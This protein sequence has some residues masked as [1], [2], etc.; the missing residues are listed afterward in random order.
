MR[1]VS[2]RRSIWI[3]VLIILVLGLVTVGS[4]FGWQRLSAPNHP[5]PTVQ[6]EEEFESQPEPVMIQLP[7]AR[8]IVAVEGDY[9]EDSHIWRLISKSN[10]LSDLDY[11]PD[12]IKPDVATRQD[13]SLDEQ[14]VRRDIAPFVEQ[15]FTAAEAAGHQLQIGSGFRSSSLQNTYYTN[16]SRVYGQAAADTFSAKPGYSEHQTGLVVDLTTT[17]H[18]CYLEA[19]F[20]ETE[21]GKWLKENSYKYGFILRY[22]LE[23]E[24]IT[25][26]NYEP[27]HF[28]Y[29]GVALAS[30]LY[31]SGLSLDEAAP[32]LVD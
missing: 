7:G 4:W 5:M 32:Y 11:R 15:L 21:A 23:K 10:P 6:L 3:F 24:G 29:V 13:K 12:I 28:R 26:F 14:S 16:Y 20:G 2:Q 25:D 8:P 19:C 1:L 9:R 27:W 22:P 18:H 31:E 17:D 30:A